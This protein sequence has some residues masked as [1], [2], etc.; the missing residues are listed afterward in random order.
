M[1]ISADTA[2][3]L[4]FA[5]RYDDAVAQAQRTLK[6]DP[7]FYYAHYLLGWAYYEKRMYQEAISECRKSLELNQEP[8][9]KA[10]LIASLAKSGGRA[11]AIKLRDEL[12]SE[13]ARHYVP[14]Y[15]LAVADIALGEK[16]EAIAA[17]EKDFAERAPSYAWIP[18]DPLFDD[19]RGDPRFAALVKRVESSKLD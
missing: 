5:R 14:N 8:Y 18:V 1:I 7:N 15:F 2:F 11:E 9:G 10:I 4:I 16:D 17:L 6:L 3:D 19:L 13:S 12:K